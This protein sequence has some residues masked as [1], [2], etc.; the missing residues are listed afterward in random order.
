MKRERRQEIIRR[1]ALYVA[2]AAESL[3]D[4]DGGLY[5]GLAEQGTPEREA[6]AAIAVETVKAL[7]RRLRKVGGR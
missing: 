6:E 5:E 4:L 3:I 1:T 2:D 7:A